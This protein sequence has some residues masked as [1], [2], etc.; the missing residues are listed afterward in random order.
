MS[1]HSNRLYDHFQRERSAFGRTV[2]A[3]TSIGV[4]F[5]L[6]FEPYLATLSRLADLDRKLIEQA[7]LI[8]KV[9][10]DVRAATS[11]IER[12]INFMGDASAYQSLY[13]DMTYWVNELED[14]EQLYDRQSRRIASLR[15]S[16][17][18]VEDSAWLRGTM[19]TRDIVRK[20]QKAYPDYDMS[21]RCFFRLEDNW[22]SCLVDRK[23]MPINERLSR[24][25]YDRTESHEITRKLSDSIEANRQQYNEGFS[26]AMG[27]AELAE[28]VRSYLE[29][30]KT[31]IRN[32]YE[33]V[34]RER[35]K[36]SDD[37]RQQQVLLTRNE[38]Q[39]ANLELRKKEISQAGRLNTPIGPLPL[40]FH[41]IL[42]PLPLIML[43]TG[44]MLLRS[45]SRLLVLRNNFQQ[46][47]PDEE[48]APDAIRLVMPMWL[49]PLGS[50]AAGLIVLVILLVPGIAAIAGMGQLVTSPGLST[51]NGQLSIALV[52][53][54]AAAGF[55]TVHYAKLCKDWRRQ[56]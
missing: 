13:D 44:I 33:Y 32:W 29:E 42:S 46:Y 51:G 5:A 26:A 53:T 16:L 4:F 25:L 21:D 6:V 11:G 10:T 50:R 56:K 38:K 7:E 39:R 48:T 31:V 20:L 1:S 35:L 23:L 47:G 36:L 27:R 52:G 12:A 55:Y 24:V 8:A 22:L 45:Q 15:S 41:N 30:E 18:S 28:W 14:F 19:P 34:A 43:V 54:L 3:V 2:L 37:A 49:D 40:A 17:E 9:Q